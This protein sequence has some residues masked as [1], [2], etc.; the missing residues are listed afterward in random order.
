MARQIG[1]GIIGIGNMGSAHA[2]MMQ[3]IPNVKLV[4]ACDIKE[5]AFDR[6]PPESRKSVVCCTDIEK[7]WQVPELEA[8]LIAVPHY[9]HVDLAI[10]A[11]EHGKHIIVEKPISVHKKEAERLLAAAE[12]H[13]ELVRSTMFNQ[14]T[15]P[16]HRKLKSMIDNG[17]LGEINRVTWIITDWF[18]TQLYYDSGDWRATWAGEGGGVLLNQCPH[19][20]DLMQWLFGLPEKV[21]AQVKIGKHHDIEVEDEVNAYLEYSGNCIANFITTTGEAPGSNRLEIAAQKGKVILENG[22]L[23]FIRNEVETGEQIR[24]STSGFAK[25]ETWECR[26]NLP[27]ESRQQHAIIVENVA[28]AIISG[29]ELIAPLAEGI[30]GLELGNA[31]LLSGLKKRTVTLP[32]DSDE[33][34]Q[35][36]GEL[37]K[38]SRFI[39]KESKEYVAENMNSTY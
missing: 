29:K 38:N 5:S 34:A 22:E 14:R 6:L 21:S 30:R 37:V 8:V 9:S 28:D 19:Q 18:R 25:P 26:I 20:L 3:D 4:A 36:L 32:I 15:L 13:P 1:F 2:R 17:D 31:M 27:V 12:K 16:A 35:M 33:Y 7:F 24:N 23:L 10:A 39:K 11:M